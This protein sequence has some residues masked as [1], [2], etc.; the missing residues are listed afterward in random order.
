VGQVSQWSFAK[1]VAAIRVL[2]VPPKERPYMSE[3]MQEKI[4]NLQRGERD[5]WKIPFYEE[6]IQFAKLPDD[7]MSKVGGAIEEV[8]IFPKEV[9]AT[10][11]QSIPFSFGISVEN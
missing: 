2:G 1:K 3:K 7:L 9:K 5:W 6:V 11:E 10:G 4:T 8:G